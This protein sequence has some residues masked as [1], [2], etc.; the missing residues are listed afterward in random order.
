MASDNSPP[1]EIIDG[2][3]QLLDSLSVSAEKIIAKDED[4]SVYE[5]KLMY[6]FR[7]YQAAQYHFENVTKHLA[8]DQALHM[9]MMEQSKTAKILANIRRKSSVSWSAN[10]YVYELSAFLEAL[11]SA[12]DFLAVIFAMY[13]PGIETDSI[14]TFIKMAQ[15]GN[16][17]LIFDVI[18]QQLDWLIS[19]RE[20][21]HHL[22]HRRIINTQS[23]HEIQELDNSTTT[24]NYPVV[25]PESTPAFVLDTRESRMHD[26][27]L[28]GFDIAE[29]KIVETQDDGS[30]KVI[31]H[32]IDVIPAAGCTTIEI[33][34][35][36][37]M[38][39]FE[40]FFV[41]SIELLNSLN[42]EAVRPANPA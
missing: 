39:Q 41:K 20:Y 4:K 11:K 37:Q 14:S 24:V 32:R 42:F 2:H 29:T 17:G 26:D 27:E 6:A 8:N 33:F 1:F 34:M 5:T 22:V 31:E 12:L 40:Y 16:D 3:F 15:K 35:A 21:R 38:E 36:N 18:S 23:R 30:E 13:F 28:H 19:L 7:K 9:K 10:Y 25:I